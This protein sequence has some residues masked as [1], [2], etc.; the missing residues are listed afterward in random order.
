MTWPKQKLWVLRTVRNGV[1]RIYGDDYAPKP[2][3][4]TFHGVHYKDRVEGGRYLFA[5]YEEGRRT[6]NYLD[7]VELWGRL[8]NP[9]SGELLVDGYIPWMSW[10]KVPVGLTGKSYRQEAK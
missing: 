5:R 10:R 9:H 3:H 6:G 2:D 7:F 4:E 1:V 8:D